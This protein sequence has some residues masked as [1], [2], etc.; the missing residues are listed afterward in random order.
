MH[1]QLAGLRYAA[2]PPLELMACDSSTDSCFW[3]K[4]PAWKAP[5]VLPVSMQEL[6]QEFHQAT[7]QLV[8]D[9]LQEQRVGI[10]FETKLWH[11]C[12]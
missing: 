6:Y 11:P 1:R 9:K 8:Q 5:D 12:P 2:W 3:P 7:E 10:G 4:M